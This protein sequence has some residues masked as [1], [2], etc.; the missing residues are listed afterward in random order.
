MKK[1]LVY[2]K[3]IMDMVVCW[4]P[5]ATIPVMA[6][7]LSRCQIVTYHISIH[8]VGWMLHTRNYHNGC[9]NTD[10]KLPPVFCDQFLVH[11]ALPVWYWRCLL[12]GSSNVMNLDQTLN[13]QSVVPHC[14]KIV[15]KQGTQ[16]NLTGSDN[17]VTFVC[18]W[19]ARLANCSKVLTV[20]LKARWQHVPMHICRKR[21]GRKMEIADKYVFIYLPSKPIQSVLKWK[22]V[23]QNNTKNA[24]IPWL[25][26][27]TYFGLYSTYGLI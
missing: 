26:H 25:L 6:V 9:K 4:T 15:M 16:R 5:Q 2:L 22:G 23:L 21:C 3:E 7:I 10:Y 17:T 8:E 27:E 11:L 18:Q 19:W 12:A 20:C 24:K 13:L 14:S 1:I